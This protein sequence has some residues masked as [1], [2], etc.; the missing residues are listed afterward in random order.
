MRGRPMVRCSAC[1]LAATYTPAG[2]TS[3][4]SLHCTRTG[5]DVDASDGCT[6]GSRGAPSTA[7]APYE[8]D[9]AQH[10]AVNGYIEV[11]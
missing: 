3:V 7:S 10:A 6:F 11:D 5:D 1:S 8:V 4:P 2:F 9:I